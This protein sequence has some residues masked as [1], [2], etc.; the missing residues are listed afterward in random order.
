MKLPNGVA[1][2]PATA[3]DQPFLQAL[4]ASTRQ[5]ELAYLPGSDADKQLFLKSQFAA[6][7]ASYRS[8][9]PRAS[10]QIIEVAEVAAG[11]WYVDRCC[12]PMHVIDIS[13]LPEYRGRGIGSALLQGLLDEAGRSGA[14]VS[15]TVDMSNPAA[16]LYERLG[17]RTVSSD[18]LYL[19]KVAS[20][21]P[22]K[23]P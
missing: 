9:F 22:M 1:L 10:L 7:T 18:G 16:R 12:A 13:L 19:R 23:I 4:F 3:A 14:A 2:R 6:Q 8:A 11:R 20:G 5:R 21:S 17:F 15:L